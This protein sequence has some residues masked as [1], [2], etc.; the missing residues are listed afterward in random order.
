MNVAQDRETMDDAL[1]LK[2]KKLK[3]KEPAIAL[4]E[5]VAARLK[6]REGSRS[7]GR[8]GPAR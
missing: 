8:E 6:E 1:A 7:Y 4:G 2:L 5:E 3:R